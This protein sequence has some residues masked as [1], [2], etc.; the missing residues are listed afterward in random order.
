MKKYILGMVLALS[1]FTAHAGLIG[2]D[3]SVN[4]VN[5]YKHLALNN[6]TC[7]INESGINL[8]LT[9]SDKFYLYGPD[10][11]T[12]KLGGQGEMDLQKMGRLKP[13]EVYHFYLH[14]IFTCCYFF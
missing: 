13:N 5:A 7:T 3:G 9:C 12:P 11:P 10:S 8:T 1:G 2:I 4:I 14:T 6:R